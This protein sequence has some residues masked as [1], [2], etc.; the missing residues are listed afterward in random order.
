[1]YNLNGSWG[2]LA[3]LELDKK[4]LG[5]VIQCLLEVQSLFFFF[6]LSLPVLEGFVVLPLCSLLHTRTTQKQIL[7][8]S[9]I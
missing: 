5:M 6:S 9:F 4:S 7:S 2:R 8:P 3:T 1:M